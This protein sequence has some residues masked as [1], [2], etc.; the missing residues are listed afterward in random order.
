M[1]SY[2]LAVLAAALF[3]LGAASTPRRVAAQDT[4]TVVEPTIP[5]ACTTLSAS[6]TA[7]GDSTLAES[8]E[9][10]LDTERIQRAIDGCASGRAV[11]LR[12]DGQRTA[13][14]SGPLR[15][16]SGVTLRIDSGAT[17]YASRDP[18]VFDVTPGACGVLAPSGRGCRPLIAVD[19]A[20]HAAVMG[21]GAIDGRGWA[22]LLGKTVSW[23]DLAQQARN[24]K[25]NQNCPRLIVATRSDDFTLYRLTL[26]HSP[27]F[28]VTYANGDGFTVWG[29]VIRTPQHN[30]R[31]TDGI[32]PGP[33]RNVTITHTTILAGDD[34]IAIKAGSAGGVSNVT[35][36]HN[37]FFRGHGMSIG[38]ETDGGV[39]RVL[40]TDLSV[41]GAD[42]GLRIKSNA[43]RGGLVQN[44]T[45]EDVCI[46]RTK[47]PILMDTHYSASPD[48]TGTLIPRFTNIRLRNVRISDGG[49]IT[50]DGYDAAHRLGIA[51]ENVAIDDLSATK[52]TARHALV[53]LVAS[54]TLVFRDA[55]EDVTVDRGSPPPASAQISAPNSC[56]GKF[57][58]PPQR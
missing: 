5:P 31:N 19:R 53:S 6:L 18:R 55:D 22:L 40:V 36:S 33:A 9:G 26:R 25:L 45:Y 14:L 34:N 8:D 2:R 1:P 35:V 24:T 21:P 56:E 27:N 43:S 52:V 41:D 51:F 7:V 15:L 28:H 16:R 50:L 39:D 44:V 54:P 12:T 30:A 46:R 17:L 3:A 11:V 58:A 38:S 57:I 37:H 47:E 23:W 49:R 42:N 4:R 29:V 10:R 20:P 13:F 48:T 32:D